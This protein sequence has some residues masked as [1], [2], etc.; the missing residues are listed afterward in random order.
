MGGL[1]LVVDDDPDNL[2]SMVDLLDEEGFEVLSARTGRE[3]QDCIGGTE[4]CLVL[5]DYVLPDMTGADLARVLRQRDGPP[6]PIVI[7]TA[8]RQVADAPRD[9]P[10][11]K[12]P[13][14]FEDLLR[15]LRQYCSTHAASHPAP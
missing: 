7:L 11:L 3:A 14:S 10:V 13:L 15:V 5:I 12:K 1:I 6:L 4:P 8:L 9:V 2:E